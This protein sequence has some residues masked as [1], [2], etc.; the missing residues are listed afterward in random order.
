MEVYDKLT[1]TDVVA[2][3]MN[4]KGQDDEEED[5]DEMEPQPAK[6]AQP[7]SAQTDTE[8]V[9]VHATQ[10]I[11]HHVTCH[12]T[13]HVIYHVTCLLRMFLHRCNCTLVLTSQAKSQAV[14]VGLEMS[15]EQRDKI[16]ASDEFITFFDR[17]SRLV[18][19]ALCEPSDIL[20]DYVGGSGEEGR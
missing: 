2:M 11:K 7:V 10:S 20:F 5:S 16:V 18:E 13:C 3:E 17:A 14:P 19:R 12:V 1:Q 15:A 6:P 4:L 8:Q 9:H